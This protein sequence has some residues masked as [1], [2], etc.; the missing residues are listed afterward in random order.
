VEAG[1]FTHPSSVP[2]GPN[3]QSQI[4][5]LFDVAP[6]AGFICS[7]GLMKA[8]KFLFLYNINLTYLFFIFKL[9]LLASLRSPHFD[10][11]R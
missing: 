8:K 7:F 5:G 4:L 11:K 3:W 9:I 2:K 6:C 1:A 10:G